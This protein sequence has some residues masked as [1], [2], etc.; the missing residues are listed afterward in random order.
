MNPHSSKLI[1]YISQEKVVSSSDVARF[2]S[3]SWNT[4]ERYLI[5]LLLEKRIVRVKREGVTLWLKA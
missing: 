5:E 4:A 2:L 3:V 1:A